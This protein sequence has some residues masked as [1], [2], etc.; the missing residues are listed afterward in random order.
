M[1]ENE[2]YI[3]VDD[4]SH[5]YT[6]PGTPAVPVV[7][8]VSLSIHKGEFV[9]LVGPSGCGKTT[10]MNMVAGLIAPNK[11]HVRVKGKDVNG[12]DPT[13]GIGYMFARD[14]L[15]PWRTTLQNV[16]L[17]LQ[18]RGDRDAEVQARKLLEL[19][20]LGGFE[21]RYRSEL[22]QGMRQ[23]AALARTL[24]PDPDILLLD[25]PFSALD[26]Q[27]KVLVEEEFMR[28]RDARQSTTIFVTHD[29]M[30]AITLADRV[31]VMSARPARIRS[32]VDI[33]FPRPRS[34][35][36]T[37]FEPGAEE[38]FKELWELLLP[39]VEEADQFS[40]TKK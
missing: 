5:D 13:L 16:A 8:N 24:A 27:T 29:L 15:M 11:G 12:V 9:A 38:L 4:V 18:L 39:E 28:I 3:V 21:G 2:P 20:G 34:L 25:E 10:V 14:G 19:V 22:S 33:P 6:S 26:A 1:A 32:V 7:R 35:T 31:V 30:E 40:E 23:R 17:G 37:R 36:E